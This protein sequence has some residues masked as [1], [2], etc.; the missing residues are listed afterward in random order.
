MGRKIT[1]RFSAAFK[2]IRSPVAAGR[3]WHLVESEARFLRSYIIRNN[4]V[5]RRVPNLVR[6]P[7]ASLRTLSL[8]LGKCIL[9]KTVSQRRS[10]FGPLERKR[11]LYLAAYSF[12]CHYRRRLHLHREE[13]G[14]R[15]LLPLN[16][17]SVEKRCSLSLSNWAPYS[18][19]M[20]GDQQARR[21]KL[22]ATFISLLSFLFFSREF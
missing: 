2:L 15:S 22:R 4:A 21:K 12:Q 13:V 6:T 7:Q 8:L 17:I 10:Q 11:Y 1:Q 14:Q 19:A 3:I 16:L 20:M 9:Q 18:G 5:N